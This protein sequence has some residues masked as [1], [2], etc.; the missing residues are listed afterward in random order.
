MFYECN[1]RS[2]ILS[3]VHTM[4]CENFN[5]KIY[6]SMLVLKIVLKLLSFSRCPDLMSPNTLTLSG[7]Y[8]TEHTHPVRILYYRTHSRCPDLISPNTLT[9]SGSYITEHIYAVYILYHRTHS[10]LSQH[11]SSILRSS[12]WSSLSPRYPRI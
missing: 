11:C 3:L 7:S 4:L 12:T 9:L 2:Q 1:W 8:I 6:F 10:Q 5:N